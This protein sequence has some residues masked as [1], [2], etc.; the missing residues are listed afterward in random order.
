MLLIKHMELEDISSHPL[1]NDLVTIETIADGSCLIHALLKAYHPVYQKNSDIDFRKSMV[2]DYRKNMSEFILKPNIRYETEEDTA[3]LI[4]EEYDTETPKNFLQFLRMMYHYND[5]Y[6]DYPNEPEDFYVNKYSFD[7]EEY[8]LYLQ[9][10]KD[11]LKRFID[12]ISNFRKDI[13]KYPFLKCKRDKLESL[14][15]EIS[16][17]LSK[18]Q[19]Y[20]MDICLYIDEHVKRLKLILE[21]LLGY[22]LYLPSFYN[23]GI[24]EYILN[25]NV[26]GEELLP[27]NLQE[28]PKGRYSELPFNCNL[29][30]L[31]KARPLMKFEME[32]NDFPDVVNLSHIHKH[33]NSRRFIGDGDVLLYIP[34]ILSIN[35]IIISFQHNCVISSYEQENSNNYII[36][37]NIDNIHFETVGLKDVNGLI[38]TLFN[39]EDDIITEL[40][41]KNKIIDFDRINEKLKDKNKGLS[42][43]ILYEKLKNKLNEDFLLEHMKNTIYVKYIQKNK[44]LYR[45][46]L[47]SKGKVISGSLTN[48]LKEFIENV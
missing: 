12:K 24:I 5:T 2:R 48:K 21:S 7:K 6:I 29:F 40:L 31:C 11:Y 16:D 15:K 44:I 18:C 47:N 4:R 33:F 46:Y 26:K 43:D 39:K 23:S 14:S 35:L 17:E 8:L 32:Y 1:C 34:E 27:I 45:F 42:I 10:Y 9:E 41:N 38:K 36:V 20:Y 3:N 37:N 19:K 25:N 22:K 13:I 28:L 30:T